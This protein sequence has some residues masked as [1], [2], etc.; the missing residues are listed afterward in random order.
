[1]QATCSSETSIYGKPT[2]RHIPEDRILQGKISF[3]V[4]ENRI[5]DSSVVKSRSLAA[6]PTEQS[7]LRATELS[8]NL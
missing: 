7:T 1:M 8:E 2:L 3:S 4:T 6:I 5:P